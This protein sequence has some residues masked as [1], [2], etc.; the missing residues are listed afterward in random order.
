MQAQ[1]EKLV[2]VASRGHDDERATVSWTIANGGLTAGLEVTMFM[3]SSAIDLIRKGAVDHVRMNPFDPPMK[4]LIESFVARGGKILVCPPCAK[5]RGYAEED[6]IEGVTI[7]GSAALHAL[8][9]DGAATL[10]F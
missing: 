1:P 4:E 5:V 8:I 7:V 6:L 9:K 2:I 3:V 10:C